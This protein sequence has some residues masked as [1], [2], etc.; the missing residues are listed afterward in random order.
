MAVVTLTAS[1]DF[2]KTGQYIARLTGRAPKVQFARE[3]VG[4]KEGKRKDTT[5]Y[6]TDEIGVYEIND[7]TRKGRDRSYWLVLPWQDELRMIRTDHEDCLAICKRLDG[8]EILAD[9]VKLERG[10]AMVNRD[11][12]P[13]LKEDGQPKHKL[14]YSILTARE[15]KSAIAG[16][17]LDLAVNSTAS[18]IVA[19]LAGLSPADQKKVLS[20]V[21]AQ[22]APKGIAMPTIEHAIK[23]GKA[24]GTEAAETLF[25]NE[26]IDDLKADQKAGELEWETEARSGRTAEISLKCDELSDELRSA[27]Y[28]AYNDAA[29]LRANAIIREGEAQ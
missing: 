27:Y 5:R 29:N 22:L 26:G 14:V 15:A 21:R 13:A 28:R 16:T 6:E 3:F 4:T 23:C 12:S 1:A 20:A 25:R 18:S 8:G 24:D 19:I 9:F 7:E 10:E 11:G 2:G 17:S